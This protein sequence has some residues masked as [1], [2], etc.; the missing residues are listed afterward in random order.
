MSI[1]SSCGHIPPSTFQTFA[2]RSSNKWRQR[3]SR[4][5]ETNWG[6]PAGPYQ[7]VLEFS[8][9]IVQTFPLLLLFLPLSPVWVGMSAPSS[10]PFLWVFLFWV[11]LGP[12]PKWIGLAPLYCI[13]CLALPLLPVSPYL[14][15][16]C[17]PKDS[18]PVGYR[19]VVPIRSTLGA[20]DTISHP[21]SVQVLGGKTT[22]NLTTTV[23]PW[24]Q[25]SY[26]ET[27]ERNS[28][29]GGR[30]KWEGLLEKTKSLTAFVPSSPLALTFFWRE[31][32]WKRVRV[33]SRCS[34]GFLQLTVKEWAEPPSQAPTHCR[35]QQQPQF[36]PLLLKSPPSSPP[37]LRLVSH[38]FQVVGVVSEE[39]WASGC[40]R[41]EKTRE[42]DLFGTED[43]VTGN[44]SATVCSL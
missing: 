12:R 14:A 31:T 9:N 30:I 6:R 35:P 8:T 13:P 17:R 10:V 43:F 3:A 37:R 1:Q 11:P 18:R 4:D 24:V 36:Q 22:F 15:C 23:G 29:A 7:I 41:R 16:L 25:V 42:R 40:E 44:K 27:W 32:Q 2:W 5:R 19:M 28:F 20:V 38:L 34:K 21:N 26:S 39:L 33:W